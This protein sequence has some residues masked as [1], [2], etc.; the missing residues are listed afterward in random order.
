[1]FVSS[2]FYG[3]LTFHLA[4]DLSLYLTSYLAKENNTCHIF[5]HGLKFSVILFD[6]LSSILSDIDSDILINIQRIEVTFCLMMS[7][8]YSGIVSGIVF[9]CGMFI[10]AKSIYF[11]RCFP[12]R[13]EKLETLNPCCAT[14]FA[15]T[16]FATG[17]GNRFAIR[18]ALVVRR[19]DSTGGAST[20]WRLG[21]GR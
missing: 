14:S 2:L 20:R 16:A 10:P 3:I 18:P 4:L 15:C 21:N 19:S 12:F 17:A 6:V 5:W 11:C 9:G 8:V 1:M 13:C 7:H